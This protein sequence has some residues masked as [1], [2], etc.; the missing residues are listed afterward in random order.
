MASPPS[1]L[2]V[3]NPST[4]SPQVASVPAANPQ[5]ATAAT[6]PDY[7]KP[8]PNSEFTPAPSSPVAPVPNTPATTNYIT[9]NPT[10]PPTPE[11][12]APFA[13]STPEPTTPDSPP[14]HT[15]NSRPRPTHEWPG[16]APFWKPEPHDHKGH[17]HTEGGPEAPPKPE[18]TLI[19]PAVQDDDFLFLDFFRKAEE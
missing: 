14:P 11:S 6:A 12:S 15:T 7:I 8:D 5:P 19:A 18:N 3:V 10:L 9:P 17:W 1:N 4:P 13:P 2:Q 16:A